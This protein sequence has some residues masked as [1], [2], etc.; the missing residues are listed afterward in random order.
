MTGFTRRALLAGGAL[1]VLAPPALAQGGDALEDILVR[2]QRLEAAYRAA[3]ERDAID[4]A[5]G[6]SL[7]AHEREHVR[8]VES[9]L[10]T[11]GR[12]RPSAGVTP[13]EQNLALGSRG[14]FARYALGLEG[15]TLAAYVTLLST[16]AAPKLLQPLGSIMTCGAQH[17]VALRAELGEPLL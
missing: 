3:L 8:G 15:E 4:P 10:R 16:L 13:P 2:E 9:A 6:E 1:A 14:A 5:L 7:L 11:L 17:E 12:G